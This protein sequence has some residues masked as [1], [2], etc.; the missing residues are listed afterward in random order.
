MLS[1]AA[2]SP[3]AR[4]EFRNYGLPLPHNWTTQRNGGKRYAVTF[5]EGALLPVMP[6]KPALVVVQMRRNLKAWRP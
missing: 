2:S 6:G 3:S 4:D 5:A 1:C